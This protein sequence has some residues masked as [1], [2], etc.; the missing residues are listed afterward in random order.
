M[1]PCQVDS[2]W[3]HADPLGVYQPHRV[4]MMIGCSP[5]KILIRAAFMHYDEKGHTILRHYAALKGRTRDCIP[6]FPGV[7]LPGYT[8]I[9]L[10][11]HAQGI[12]ILFGH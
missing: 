8:D 12:Q 9:N 4:G 2:Q 10:S 11:D 6:D 1:Q 5:S 7:K 3:H